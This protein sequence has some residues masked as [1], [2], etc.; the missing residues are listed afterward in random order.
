M[1]KLLAYEFGDMSLEKSYHKKYAKDHIY[2]EW[3]LPTDELMNHINSLNRVD[4][5]CE[6]LRLSSPRGDECHN[7]KEEKYGAGRDDEGEF[8]EMDPG[9]DASV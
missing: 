6:D 3:F 1:L 4:I 9:S 2:G 5:V 8:G 7:W